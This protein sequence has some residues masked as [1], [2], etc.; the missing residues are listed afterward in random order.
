VSH[1]RG[2]AQLNG[3]VK[4][5]LARRHKEL[6]ASLERQVRDTGDELSAAAR[7][8]AAAQ[9]DADDARR[10]L[11]DE[12]RVA[13]VHRLEEEAAGARARLETKESDLA[14]VRA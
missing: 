7:K 6:V 1:S 3:L 2:C 8:A 12:A 5:A 10:L 14:K 11:H 9:A 13:K 4:D